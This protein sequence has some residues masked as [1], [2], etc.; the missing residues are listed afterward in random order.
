M[1]QQYTM[2]SQR[3]LAEEGIGTAEAWASENAE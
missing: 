1:F 3:F 2:A